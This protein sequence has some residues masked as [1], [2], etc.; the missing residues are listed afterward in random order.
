MN[1]RQ[2][3][4]SGVKISYGIGLD[5]PIPKFKYIFCAPNKSFDYAT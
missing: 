4:A 1:D 5:P 3:F 2:M